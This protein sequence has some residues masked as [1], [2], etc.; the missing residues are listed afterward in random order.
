MPEG[1]FTIVDN[2]RRILCAF[3]CKLHTPYETWC[4][5]YVEDHPRDLP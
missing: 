4:D 2:S 1:G 3:F 5:S